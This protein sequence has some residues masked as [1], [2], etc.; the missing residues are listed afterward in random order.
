MSVPT[1]YLVV[2]NEED[3]STWK[4]E[5]LVVKEKRV[6]GGRGGQRLLML[7]RE[8]KVLKL[9]KPKAYFHSNM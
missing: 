4:H 1:R 2:L 8:T 5:K 3:R 7:K 9:K 6:G